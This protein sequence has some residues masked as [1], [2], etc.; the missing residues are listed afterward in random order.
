[1]QSLNEEQSAF[2]KAVNNNFGRVISNKVIDREKLMREEP[3]SS[4]TE[5]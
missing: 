5:T 2:S 3:I 1:M 4:K